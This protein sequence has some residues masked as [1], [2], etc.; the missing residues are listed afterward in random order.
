[1]IKHRLLLG[2]K[3]E[4][5]LVLPGRVCLLCVC[6]GGE[7]INNAVTIRD[8]VTSNNLLTDKS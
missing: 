5:A 7:V 2:L 1:M 8:W 6:V 3:T 4:K